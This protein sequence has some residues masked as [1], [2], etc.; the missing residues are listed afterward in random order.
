MHGQRKSSWMFHRDEVDLLEEEIE[1][2]YQRH[3]KTKGIISEMESDV[4][5][6]QL[7]TEDRSEAEITIELG[8]ELF[9]A[10]AYAL[11]VDLDTPEAPVSLVEALKQ[12]SRR[13]PVYEAIFLWANDVFEFAKTNYLENVDT[14]RDM[15]RVYVNVKMVP[16]K[17]ATAFS[18]EMLED[19]FSIEIAEKEY[20]LALTYLDRTIDSLQHIGFLGSVRAVAFDTQGREFRMPILAAIERMRKNKNRKKSL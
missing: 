17:F 14:G 1:D 4:I 11:P 6:E 10:E 5:S 20:E 12:H 8:A 16:I 18:E 2:L 13:D 15:F 3:Q 7:D 19:V 9:N